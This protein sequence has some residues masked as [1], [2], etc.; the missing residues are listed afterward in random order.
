MKHLRLKHTWLC[1]I[2]LFL[3]AVL[4]LA[5][6][7]SILAMNETWFNIL[8][9][10][11]CMLSALAYLLL[12]FPFILGTEVVLEEIRYHQKNRLWFSLH[13]LGDSPEAVRAT[14]LRHIAR[15]GEPCTDFAVSRIKPAQVQYRRYGSLSSWYSSSE[16]IIH[17]YEVAQLDRTTYQ[18][19]LESSKQ[20]TAQLKKKSRPGMLLT[21]EEKHAPTC[22]AVAVIILT[23]IAEPDIP[24]LVRKKREYNDTAILPCVVEL[25]SRR[26][27]FDGKREVYMAGS[28]PT[29]AKN[30]A[31]D[32]I[33]KV[34]FGGHLP[35]KGNDAFD[36]SCMEPDFPETTLIEY[37]QEFWREWRKDKNDTAKIAARMHGGEVLEKEDL[38]FIKYNGRVTTFLMDKEAEAIVLFP[39]ETWEYPK[40]QRISKA[41]RATLKEK[42]VRYFAGKNQTVIF[43]DAE[44]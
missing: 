33:V 29:P 42:A 30:R 19:I 11:L 7:F 14:L 41:D 15:H 22:R 27:W 31:I 5:L 10:F 39:S 32:L 1:Q 4:L 16:K 44:D 18:S 24:A 37:F 20:I 3:P 8:L 38:L 17:L 12:F 34:V 36:Y 2:L 23:N 28:L 13:S 26:C 43:A 21:K 9:F 40:Q 6:G 25:S 35:L